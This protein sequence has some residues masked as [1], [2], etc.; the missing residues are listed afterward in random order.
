MLC[1]SCAVNPFLYAW[2]IPQYR[3]ALRAVCRTTFSRL[4]KF[5]RTEHSCRGSNSTKARA[6][7]IA[8]TWARDQNALSGAQL[9]LLFMERD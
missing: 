8:K 1:V 2:R 3:Q 6:T 5:N 4:W 7:K 9:I